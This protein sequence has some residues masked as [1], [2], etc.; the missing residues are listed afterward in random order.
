MCS[1]HVAGVGV[2]DHRTLCH[3]A[4]L[5]ELLPLLALEGLLCDT[6]AGIRPHMCTRTALGCVVCSHWGS[7]KDVVSGSG[8]WPGPI[9]QVFPSEKNTLSLPSQNMGHL[10]WPLPLVHLEPRPCCF[11]QCEAL[12]SGGIALQKDEGTRVCSEHSFPASP[13]LPQ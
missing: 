2:S 8:W 4:H 11:C 3:A 10:A 6:Q 9:P 12:G 1:G 13:P 5:M 7:Q